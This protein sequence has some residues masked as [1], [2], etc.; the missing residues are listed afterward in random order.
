MSDKDGNCEWCHEQPA[1]YRR[2]Y[3]SRQ[4]QS[5]ARMWRRYKTA[6]ERNAIRRWTREKML[7]DGSILAND[8][9]YIFD[10]CGVQLTPIHPE[11]SNETG[12][13]KNG[14]CVWCHEGPVIYLDGYY[15]YCSEFCCDMYRRWR[16]ALT[17]N[18]VHDKN[19][20]FLTT[21]GKMLWDG[22]MTPDDDIHILDEYGV[23]MTHAHVHDSKQRVGMIDAE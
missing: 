17:L 6:Y 20:V 3:C 21:Y 2:K 11:D 16:R 7:A 9:V 19:V 5:L 18:N 12:P 15:R 23:V 14:N 13:D 10:N 4:C 1:T 22:T 8:D